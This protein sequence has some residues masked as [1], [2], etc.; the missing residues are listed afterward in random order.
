MRHTSFKRAARRRYVAAA[1]AVAVLAFALLYAPWPGLT[2]HAAPLFVAGALL[3][4]WLYA[5]RRRAEREVRRLTLQQ[6]AVAELGRRALSGLSPSELMNVAVSAVA[7]RTGAESAVL[8]EV[9]PGGWFMSARASV[10]W[11]DEFVEGATVDLGAESMLSRAFDSAEPVIIT[12]HTSDP[13]L[14][15][16]PRLRREARSC[17]SVAVRGRATTFGVLSVYTDERRGFTEGDVHFIQSVAGVL[18]SAV[19]RELREAERSRPLR[20]SA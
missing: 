13:R 17:L 7:R 3:V 14:A 10:G 19:E 5:A 8:W 9:L 20:H 18:S 15:E 11:T 12:R 1:L 4:I 16:P 6:G 2:P